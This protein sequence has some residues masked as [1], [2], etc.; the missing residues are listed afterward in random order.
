M[1]NIDR[2]IDKM[3][4]SQAAHP[5]RYLL[6]V[7]LFTALAAIFAAQLKFDSSYEAL[8]P[9][10]APQIANTNAV[11]DRTGGTRQLVVAISGR[12]APERRAFAELLA[13]RIRSLKNIKSVDTDFSIDFLEKRALW[14][15]SADNLKQLAEAV[16]E[17]IEVTS[18]NAGPLALHIDAAEEEAQLKE[19]WAKVQEVVNRERK[20]VPLKT[21]L[22]SKDGRYYFVL[23]VPTINFAD[24]EAGRNLLKDIRHIVEQLGPPGQGFGIDF[25][26]NLSVLEEQHHTMS[27]DLRNASIIA[28]LFGIFI[29]A[30]VSRRLATPF[31]I[32]TSLIAGI[33]WTFALTYLTI[34]HVNIITGFLGSVLIGL[35]IDFGIHLYMRY[36]QERTSLGTDPL[37]AMVNSVNLTFRPAL[38]SCLTTAGTFYTFSLADFRG[39]SEFGVIAGSGVLFTLFSSF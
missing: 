20:K 24:I 34:G 32:G 37:N 35:G 5:W 8:L 6:G 18:F 13:Q 21:S 36:Q 15:M 23:V 11:R 26:G 10:N 27:A 33:T 16:D 25:A 30:F 22:E 19:A 12:S 2:L 14:L 3:A 29:V 28:L 31:L 1:S 39:F 9:K 17:A 7:F 38:T 4:R